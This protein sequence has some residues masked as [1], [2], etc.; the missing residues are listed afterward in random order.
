MWLF[1]DKSIPKI[2]TL[3][4]VLGLIIITLE[5]TFEVFKLRPESLSKPME[6]T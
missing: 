1:A 6:A 3:F 4:S 2:S 5:I